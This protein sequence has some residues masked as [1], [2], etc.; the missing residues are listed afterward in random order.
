MNPLPINLQ[1]IIGSYC[2]FIYRTLLSAVVRIQAKDTQAQIETGQRGEE[3]R[4]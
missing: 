2:T 3:A 4:E 1:S